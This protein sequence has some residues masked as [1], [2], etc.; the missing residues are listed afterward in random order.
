MTIP[1]MIS[2]RA[3]FLQTQLQ[4]LYQSIVA[5]GVTFLFDYNSILL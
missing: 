5:F 2:V 3:K 4:N 1:I